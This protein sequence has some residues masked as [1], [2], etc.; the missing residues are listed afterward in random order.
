VHRDVKL[1]NAAVDKKGLVK[2]MDFGIAH[3]ARTSSCD[4]LSETVEGTPGFMAPEVVKGGRADGRADIY[5]LGVVAF[6]IT[7]GRPP[8][9]ATTVRECL[10]AHVTETA[11]DPTSL[12]PS[13]PRGLADFIRGAL[14]KDPE[15]RLGDWDRI[16]RMFDDSPVAEPRT[17]SMAERLVRVR[18]A[19][20]V[21][22]RVIKAIENFT[23]EMKDV[24]GTDV[25]WAEMA[26][27]SAPGMDFGE[28][29]V[30]ED[31]FDSPKT[32][33]DTFNGGILAAPTIPIKKKV[34]KKR[35]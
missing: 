2:L 7:T 15:R 25:A 28:E 34:N 24:D 6:L 4:E 26:A 18:Y 16:L 8:F 32:G 23:L 1:T 19:P 3:H 20:E 17:D 29:I 30:A 14:V 22:A 35:E 5:S 12:R 13:I 10:K 33:C 11:P 27:P 9:N 21:E 31:Q